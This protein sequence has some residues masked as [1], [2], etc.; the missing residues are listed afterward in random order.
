MDHRPQDTCHHP[1]LVLYCYSI[2]LQ[3]YFKPAAHISFSRALFQLF[4]G[5]LVP[6]WPGIVHCSACLATLS[7]LLFSVF[8]DQLHFLLPAQTPAWFLIRFCSQF[9]LKFYCC[10]GMW[11][12]QQVRHKVQF[13]Y[14]QQ[15][16]CYSTYMPR[17]FRLSVRLLHACIVS[18]WLIASSK[19]LTIW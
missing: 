8:Q 7:S 16:I 17:Q 2:F 10:L 5:C 3:L 19:F 13:Y 6:P 4:F 11:F 15:H 14:A 1:A 12:S 9:C 18:K